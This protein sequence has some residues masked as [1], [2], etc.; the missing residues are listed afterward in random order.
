MMATETLRPNA[1]GKYTLLSKNG[2]S[3]NYDRVMEAVADEDSTYVYTGG[4]SLFDTYNLPAHSA[5]SGTINSVTVYFR[6]RKTDVGDTKARAHIQTHSTPYEGA[7]KSLTTSW[8]TYSET[9]TTNPNTGAAWTWDEIDA[10]EIGVRMGVGEQPPCQCT[11]VY[12]EVEYSASSY[13]Q[14]IMLWG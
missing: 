9:W 11:Q 8:V 4:A 14:H 1:A 2:G 13:S 6:C 5:G 10:L 7:Q 3:A 12:V